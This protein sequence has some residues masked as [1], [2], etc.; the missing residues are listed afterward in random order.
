MKP[1][2]LDYLKTQRVGV[3]AMEMPDGAPHAATVHFFHTEVPLVFYYETLSDTFK[4]KALNNKSKVR[5]S[6]VV[7]TVE[8][9][10]KTLQL[11]GEAELLSGTGLA[12]FKKLYF[13]KFPEKADKADDH[14][15]IYFKFTPS[16]WRF[17]DWTTANGKVIL[18]SDQ[19]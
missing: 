9:E 8:G 3:I 6:F 7:G 19:E 10:M 13:A 4:A 5:S 18:L 12:N 17:T 16:W 11:D 15:V 1:Q 14:K 2:V